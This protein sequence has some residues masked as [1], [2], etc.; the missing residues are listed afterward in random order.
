[1]PTSAN[2]GTSG[3]S[4]RRVVLVT[5]NAR[6]LPSRMCG[7]S[8]DSSVGADLDAPGQQI[9]QR[10]RAA[11]VGNVDSVHPALGADVLAQEPK[12]RALRGTE[13]QFS[14]IGF[15]IGDELA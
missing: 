10:L 13:A 3:I 5:A 1:M 6:T 8:S 15:R 7:S 11:L 14:R 4:G 9:G 2:V 12:G